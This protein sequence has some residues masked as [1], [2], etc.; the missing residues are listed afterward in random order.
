MSRLRRLLHRLVRPD[1]RKRP[2]VSPTFLAILLCLG[3]VSGGLAVLNSELRSS[4]P[5]SPDTHT[6]YVGCTY[7]EVAS[8]LVDGD[9]LCVPNDVFDAWRLDHPSAEIVR[10]EPIYENG[11][12]VGFQVTFV[13]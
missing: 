8:D 12:F 13:E 3:A 2:W 10:K 5:A 6:E 7:A 1:P 9:A 4:S 11:L